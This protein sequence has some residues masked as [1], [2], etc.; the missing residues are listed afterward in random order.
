MTAATYLWKAR[1]VVNLNEVRVIKLDTGGN[2][3]WMRPFENS[4]KPSL[5][6]TP[7]G[8]YLVVGNYAGYDPSSYDTHSR[9]A[10]I[11]KFDKYVMKS[12]AG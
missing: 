9:D 1:H 10:W 5:Q 7:D 2:T 12:G 8:G 4:L 3:T 11:I 6:Q